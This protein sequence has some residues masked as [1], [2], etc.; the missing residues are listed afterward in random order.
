MDRQ[1]AARFVLIGAIICLLSGY[2]FS[3]FRTEAI[4]FGL[5]FGVNGLVLV[6]EDGDW[7]Q[8]A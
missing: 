8:S 3:A 4:V 7:S 6:P 2:V 5:W 1:L